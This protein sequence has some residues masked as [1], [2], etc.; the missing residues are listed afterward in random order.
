MQIVDS[1]CELC[2]FGSQQ[3]I[4]A[5]LLLASAQEI[6]QEKDYYRD[7]AKVQKKQVSR[8]ARVCNKVCWPR[9]SLT[10]PISY[11]TVKLELVIDPKSQCTE[12][13]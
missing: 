8:A 13:V 6:N 1:L 7:Y 11:L 10:I 4:D 3:V 5:I 2:E 12:Q 9:K